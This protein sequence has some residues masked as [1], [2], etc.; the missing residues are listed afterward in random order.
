MSL[1]AQLASAIG[2]GSFGGRLWLYSNYHC[3]LACTYCLT[4]SSPSVPKRALGREKMVSLARQAAGLGF[5]GIGITGGEPF[6]LPYLVDAVEEISGVLPVTLLTNGTLFNA[7]RLQEVARLGGRDVRMQISLD[8]PEPSANDAMRGPGNFAKVLDAVPRLLALGIHVRI[9]TTVE[10]QTP[11]EGSRLAD[12]VRSLGVPEEDH[13]VRKIVR[14]GRA[15][16]EDLGVS[17]PLDRLSP[18]LTVTVDGAF[19]SPFAPT[20]FWPENP[21]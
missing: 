1:G 5:K 21:P 3:N 6:L 13:V 19:W 16:L 12:L 7:A 15:D 20:C 4:E 14:R 10:D 2:E 17:A 11:E 8:R 18:E 9:A